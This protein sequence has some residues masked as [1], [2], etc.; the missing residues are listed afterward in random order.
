MVSFLQCFAPPPHHSLSSWWVSGGSQEPVPPT[1]T[2]RKRKKNTARPARAGPTGLRVFET[3]ERIS[4]GVTA[5]ILGPAGAAFD[6]YGEWKTAE[7]RCSAEASI[8]AQDRGPGSLKRV[9]NAGLPFSLRCL[10]AFLELPVHSA[11]RQRWRIS[12]HRVRNSL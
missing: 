1:P 10:R 12:F 2:R 6:F 3:K 7:R 8:R 11:I 9:L 4:K 5:G